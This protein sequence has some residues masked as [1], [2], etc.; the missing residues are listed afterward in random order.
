MGVCPTVLKMDHIHQNFLE[1]FSV[2]VSRKKEVKSVRA[3]VGMVWSCREQ[4]CVS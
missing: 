4:K 2:V 1:Y 3:A